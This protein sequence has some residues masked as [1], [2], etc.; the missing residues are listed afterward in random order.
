[1]AVQPTSAHRD[2]HLRLHCVNV[3]VRDQDRS[4]RFYLDQLGFYLAFDTHLQSGERWVAV[5]PPDGSA[6][7]ALVVPKKDAP[8][9]KL[10]GRATNVV[11][12]A[13]SASASCCR[14]TRWRFTRTASPNR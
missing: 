2:P 1:M 3:F 13:K 12:I 5:S 7:L 8:Q 4:L 14:A 11:F 9:Y 6:L 10:I